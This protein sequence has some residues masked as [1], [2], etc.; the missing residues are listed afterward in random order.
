MLET[1]FRVVVTILFV[2]SV[3]LCSFAI[4][5]MIIVPSQIF[6]IAAVVGITNHYFKFVIDSPFSML[7]QTIV[8]TIMVMVTK[9]YPALYA[10]LVTFTGSII[11]SLIDAPV[12]I[13]AMQTGFAA[14]EDMRN[15]L[16]VFTVLHIITGALLVGISTLLIRL[17][18]GFSFIIRRYE[19]NSILRASNFIWASIL[20]GALLFFQFTYARLPVLS[21]HGYILMLMAATMLV[22]L[23][24]A[25]RQNYKSAEARKGRTL[26]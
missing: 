1:V 4:F 15:N 23:W 22:V 7:A 19:G 18:A 16:L 6:T 9:R 12:T 5:R 11:V 21:M 8:F 10:L 17:K 24:Y 26:T 14:V 20:L 3:V 25:I 13:L 2:S